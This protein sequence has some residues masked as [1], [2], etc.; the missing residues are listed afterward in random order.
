M[1][2]HRE[3]V[4][5]T[6]IL[7]QGDDLVRL[8]RALEREQ[9]AHGLVGDRAGALV[10]DDRR[11]VDRGDV[12]RRAEAVL[13]DVA[14]LRVVAV[15]AAQARDGRVHAL[16]DEELERRQHAAVDHAGAD[17]LAAAAVDLDA[18]VREHVA[19]TSWSLL[20]SRTWPAVSLRRLAVAADD[21]AAVA[22]DLRRVE[23]APA[24]ED[25]LRVDARRAAAGGADLEPEM[26]C[27][28]DVLGARRPSARRVRRRRRSR[29]RGS[30]D[31]RPTWPRIVPPITC[32]PLRSGSSFT[33]SRVERVGLREP[34]V[35]GADAGRQAAAE[36]RADGR[37][38]AVE[39]L[40]ERRVVAARPPGSRRL[41]RRPRCRGG[42][43]SRRGL[44]L[45]VVAVEAELVA[46]RAPA[47]A[48]LA[49]HRV[50]RR[51]SSRGGRRRSG[52][53]RRRA[54]G[55][56]CR[57]ARSRPCRRR[58]RPGPRR[59]RRRHARRCASRGGCRRPRSASEALRP[60]TWA[61]LRADAAGV[62][63]A[64]GDREAAERQ[65]RRARRRPRRAAR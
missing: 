6:R 41:R 54:G 36:H 46:D 18:R 31:A 9:R 52:C 34:G 15:A 45:R 27:A 59:R 8:H 50:R 64:C 21:R 17:V 49:R 65:A 24:V 57:G 62:A 55:R 37:A 43:P 23:Q 2:G 22:V 53:R 51:R 19:L 26:R 29:P 40:C 35:V 38:R 60:E 13:G 39:K 28:L 12:D 61:L 16:G 30:S 44:G 42:R 7:H 47:A 1:I 3:R 20:I 33:S 5:R 10:A 56:T 11:A 14:A 63:G 25:R 32:E 48:P 4:V 58:R